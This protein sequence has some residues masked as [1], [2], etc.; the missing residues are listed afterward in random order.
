MTSIQRIFEEH[1]LRSHLSLEHLRQKKPIENQDKQWLSNVEEGKNVLSKALK[2]A[3]KKADD[4]WLKCQV[5]IKNKNQ[6]IPGPKKLLSTDDLKKFK[7][8]V[9][10]PKGTCTTGT[11]PGIVTTT[12]TTGKTLAEYYT[13]INRYI[14]LYA[15][16]DTAIGTDTD[17]DDVVTE[18]VEETSS[19]S[20][21]VSI[22]TKLVKP[23]NNSPRWVY[24]ITHSSKHAR[25]GERKKRKKENV[26]SE[27][28]ERDRKTRELR[29]RKAH[30]RLAA[31]IRTSFDSSKINYP[32]KGH[33]RRGS[34]KVVEALNKPQGNHV[35]KV[36]EFLSSAICPYCFARLVKYINVMER[37]VFQV[38]QNAV[39]I[40]CALVDQNIGR[41]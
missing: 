1:R 24:S 36:D 10:D 40:L 22:I 2:E 18:E 8:L 29:T 37:S 15:L 26:K 4:Q 7:S 12:T 23:V 5:R 13:D 6:T 20:N 34:R 9:L 11:D 41:R 33:A 17:D 39:L 21:I 25:C 3:R 32:I 14:A 30:E 31:N 27:K 28:L 16:P 38:D 19:S 35:I